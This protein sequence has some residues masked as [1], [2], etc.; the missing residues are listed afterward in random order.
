MT[1][2][3]L[4]LIFFMMYLIIQYFMGLSIIE[5]LD[6]CSSD[7]HDLTY[8]NTAT[9]EQQQNEINDFKKTMESRLKTLQSKVTGFN[10]AIVKNKI[11]VA[12]NA[13]T[14]KSTVSD[15]ND[16]KNQKAKELD[17]AAGLG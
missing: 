12:K 14:I 8:K 17:A 4:I 9:I 15:I 10:T 11:N 7:Q 5:G 13:T 1:T 6:N 3:I 2:L 16:A